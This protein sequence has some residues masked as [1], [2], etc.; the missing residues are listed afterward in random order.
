[1]GTCMSTSAVSSR[2]S[3]TGESANRVRLHTGKSGTITS[4][5]RVHR[6]A[7]PRNDGGRCERGAS[8]RPDPVAVKAVGHAVAE[9][10]QGDRTCLHVGRVEYGEIAAV[11]A[12]APDHGEQPAVAL[13]GILAALDEYRLGNGVAGGQ[14]IFAEPFAFAVDMDDT[15]Q[16]AEHRPF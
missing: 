4:G 7:M 13:G 6:C 3:P 5:F 8:S 16:R 10:D 11:F 12:R 1:M 9:M 15:G 2:H 14:E